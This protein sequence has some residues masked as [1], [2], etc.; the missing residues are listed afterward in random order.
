[1]PRLAYRDP[2]T[3]LPNRALFNDRLRVAIEV[4]KRVGSAPHRAAHGPRPLQ[5]HQRHARPPHRRP[6]AAAGR[7]AAGGACV[8]KSDTIARLGGDEFAVLLLN[9]DVDEARGGRSK[10]MRGAGGADRRSASTRSTCAPAS[11][12]RASRRT[13]RMPT[14]LL[15]HADAAMYAAKRANR[16]VAVYEPRIHE[17]RR[18]ASCRCCRELRQAIER[19]ELRLVY[20][21]KVPCRRGESRPASRRWCAGSTRRRAWCPPDRFI[22]FAEQTGFIRTITA[23]GDRCARR[24]RPRAG[25]R[26]R[27]ACKVSVNISV[28]DLLEPGADRR[29]ARLRSSATSCRPQLLCLEITES[30]GDAGRRARDRDAAS[31][32]TRSASAA[33]STTSAPAT[34]RSPTSSSSPVDELKIDRSFIRNLVS[35]AEGPRDRALDHRPRAQ[36]RAR[37]WSPKASRTRRPRICCATSAATRCRA[38]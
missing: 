30:G 27:R 7:A 5:E 1:M 32:C 11:A 16:G 25:A 38:T 2:L 13:A 4:A 9:A 23:L 8:R 20:Q 18:G 28:Q 6:G 33:R 36:P 21:P 29:A 3:D 34:R 12:S 22:P 37:R 10:I 15:R 31:A 19:G 26:R 17:L 24:A 14:T 35:D